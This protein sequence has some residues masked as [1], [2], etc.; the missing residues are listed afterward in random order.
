MV[1]RLLVGMV[2]AVGVLTWMPELVAAEPLW[3]KCEAPGVKG[4]GVS[5][6]AAAAS[7]TSRKDG[8][9]TFTIGVLP[10]ESTL[11]AEGK[12]ITFFKRLTADRVHVRIDV[13]GDWFALD[14]GTT[15][16]ARLTRNGKSMTLSMTAAREEVA[17]AQ[18]FAAGSK[19]LAGFESLA[20][21]LDSSTRP[22]AQSV[23]TSF[24]LLHA[25]RGSVAPARELA[26]TVQA[27]HAGNARRASW[28][29]GEEM[30]YACWID[31]ATT[32]SLYTAEYSQCYL[33]YGWI[34]GLQAVCTFEWVVR[35]EL[36]WFWL[37][38]CSGG[39]PA[40]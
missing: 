3:A 20:S 32:V 40:V 7:S 17:K 12:G 9:V 34:P 18:Q 13:P 19:A 11:R 10:G 36:A 16:T 28:K 14:A 5:P 8:D 2:V 23:L 31:Y 1:R 25:V 33:D 30:P 22:E 4:A 35:V 39:F 24:A 26:R 27:M 29:T 21:A 37:I 6:F 15:G 38:G